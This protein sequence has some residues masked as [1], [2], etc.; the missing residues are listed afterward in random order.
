MTAI[1]SAGNLLNYV[2]GVGGLISCAQIIH[3]AY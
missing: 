1:C 2:G 3:V